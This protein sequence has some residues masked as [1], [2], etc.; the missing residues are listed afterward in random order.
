MALEYLLF[1]LLEEKGIECV[2]DTLT[3]KGVNYFCIVLYKN[4]KLIASKL[5]GKEDLSQLHT[6]IWNTVNKFEEVEG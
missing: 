5:F 4:K 2:V 3:E 1:Q 6:F